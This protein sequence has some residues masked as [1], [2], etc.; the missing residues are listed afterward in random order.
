[1]E[2]DSA[3]KKKGYTAKSYQKALSE[4]LLLVYDG[5]RRFQQDN[6]R[7]HNFGGTPQFLQ[8]HGVEYIDWPP[9]SPDLN[10]IEHV[11]RLLKDKLAELCPH[12]AELKKNQASIE[13][14]E[15]HL[16]SAWEAIPQ[17]RIDS[18]L[19]SLPR[20]LAART[21]FVS[22]INPL[23]I[24][25]TCYHDRLH[26]QR[27]CNLS[28]R[29]Y[30]F[31]QLTI[32]L[33]SGVRLLKRLWRSASIAGMASWELLD[34]KSETDLHKTRLLNVEEKPFKRITKRLVTISST[35]S[36]AAREGSEPPSPLLSSD[37]LQIDLTHDFAAFDSSIARFQFLHDANERER[38]RYAGD[39]QRILAECQS[40]RDN[41]AR[42]REQLESARAT[43]SQRKKFDELAEKITSNRLLRPR[44]DQLVNLAKL[45]DECRE[46]ERERETYSETWKERRD[47]FNR[48]M[49]EGMML[50]RLIRDEKEEVDRREGMNEGDDDDAD[51]EKEGQ[52]P[53]NLTSEQATPHPDGD[54]Q[55]KAGESTVDTPRPVSPNGGRTPMSG[56]PGPD[57]LLARSALANEARRRLEARDASAAS[58]PGAEDESRDDLEMNGSRNATA[59]ADEDGKQE[60]AQQGDIR[61]QPGKT[62]DGMEVDE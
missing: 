12:L 39:Q 2:R 7:I 19:S 42:L 6:A 31:L 59:E 55:A 30:Q 28:R 34:D 9:H 18:L 47:Q 44:E 3:A 27:P 57:K 11:W 4:G 16:R 45:E 23:Q 20:R 21:L 5:T 46:L 53:R 50:R 54:S 60:E 10:P 29:L 14:L 13:E 36:D 33:G 48:I 25:T 24:S 52:T 40:V 62:E 1:M 15:A 49:E 61:D 58:D 8:L 17:D 51:G 56:S 41:N 43:L 37:S 32:E 22:T 35:V 38:E 26:P